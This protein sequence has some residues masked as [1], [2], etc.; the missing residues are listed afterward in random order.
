MTPVPQQGQTPAGLTITADALHDLLVN[1]PALALHLLVMG[2]LRA[3]HR[4][5]ATDIESGRCDAFSLQPFE[6][7]VAGYPNLAL[8]QHSNGATG[9][10]SELISA[11][12]KQKADIG[13]A[14][15]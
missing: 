8:R 7:C 3:L 15:I 12:P 4:R 6:L 13:L 10:S 1:R 14:L 9:L 11:I 5:S 2:F